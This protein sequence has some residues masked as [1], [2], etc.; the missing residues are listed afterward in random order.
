MKFFR[1]HIRLAATFM[2]LIF[3]QSLVLPTSLKALT[4]GA[5]QSEFSS[6]EPYDT[7]DMV[8]LATGDFTY[9]MPLIHVPSPE[10]GY[11]LSLSYHAGIRPEQVSG[12]VGLGW[13]INPG[14]ITRGVNSLPD[15]W[16]AS[17]MNLYTYDD[18]EVY[19]EW[20][21]SVN[22]SPKNSPVGGGF[23]VSHNNQ[24]GFG[25]SVDIGTS[26]ANASVGTDGWSAGLGLP[27]DF[28]KEA[29]EGGARMFAGY[30]GF[31]YGSSG[32]GITGRISPNG[33]Y[34][35]TKKGLA[36]KLISRS[37][38]LGMNLSAK[39]SGGYLSTPL[40]LLSVG[41][42]AGSNDVQ[43]RKFSFFVPIPIKP[44]LIW[45]TFRYRYFK[46]WL[47]KHD[48]K[49]AYGSLY[50][51]NGK[52]S[53]G[54]IPF[55]NDVYEDY[56]ISFP[57]FDDY[58][59]AAQGVS[60]KMKPRPLEMGNVL[61]ESK[62]LDY[63][64]GN[65]D[66]KKRTQVNY[67]QEDDFDFNKEASEIYF[68]FEN[69][70]SG[71]LRHQPGTLTGTLSET[72]G[73]SSSSINS[74]GVTK[75]TQNSKGESYYHAG[76][77][78]M[79]QGRHIEWFTNEMIDAAHQGQASGQRVWDAGFVEDPT[80]S[81]KRANADEVEAKGVGGFVV[82]AQDGKQYH[83]S[84]PVYNFE[85]IRV[86]EDKTDPE[87]K[88]F[89]SN[90]YDKFA[91]TW[92]LTA[93]TGPDYIDRNGDHQVDGG[94]WG[95]WVKFTYGNYTDF[96]GWANPYDYQNAS[97]NQNT[98]QYS[99]GRKEVYY[100]DAIETRSHT[101]YFL[102]S[103]KDD[104]QSVDFLRTLSHTSKIKKANRTMFNA[105]DFPF[106][107]C[108]D[109]NGNAY[110]PPVTVSSAGSYDY[111]IKEVERDMEM[112]VPHVNML[113]LDKI[114]LVKN[115][116][117]QLNGTEAS[118]TPVTGTANLLDNRRKLVE[119]SLDLGPGVPRIWSNYGYIC[120]SSSNWSVP[121]SPGPGFVRHDQ[122]IGTDDLLSW[123]STHGSSASHILEEIEFDQDYTL[124]P[125]TPNSRWNPSNPTIKD[126]KLT[127]NAVKFHG[128]GGAL[129]MPSYQFEYNQATLNPVYNETSSDAWGY[130]G[131]EN[132][133][134]NK[135]NVSAWSLAKIYFPEGGEM[136]IE[137]ESDS[138]HREAA[139]HRLPSLT[140][141]DANATNNNTRFE[142]TCD[143]QNI[144][145]TDWFIVGR[146]YPIEMFVLGEDSS[147]QAYS[148]GDEIPSTNQYF[149]EGDVIGS[150]TLHSK[151]VNGNGETVLVFDS[152][153]SIT[154][155]TWQA[156]DASIV[157]AGGKIESKDGI[158]YGGGLRVKNI[159]ISDGSGNDYTTKYDYSHPFENDGETSG[160]TSYSPYG[161]A[162]VPYVH[163]V[164]GP[165]VM[166]EYVTTWSEAVNGEQGSKTRY[167]FKVLPQLETAGSS[168]LTNFEMSLG[169]LF[170]VEDIQSSGS[171]GYLHAT[172]QRPN[173]CPNCSTELNLRSTILHNNLGG[174]GN[175]LEVETFDGF[176]DKI[177]HNQTEFYDPT[178]ADVGVFQES[179]HTSKQVLHYDTN[180]DYWDEFYSTNASRYYYP[181]QPKSSIAT[182]SVGKTS[183]LVDNY[184]L[185]TGQPRTT[186]SQNKLNEVFKSEVVHAAPRGTVGSWNPNAQYAEMGS[187]LFDISNKNMLTQGIYSKT[188]T[189]T[190]NLTLDQIT[191]FST[192]NWKTLDASAQTWNED[193]DYREY[194]SGSNSYLYV[195]SSDP[196]WRL[197]GTYIWKGFLNDDGTYDNS[198]QD[199]DP[200]NPESNGWIRVSKVTHYDPYSNIL[201]STYPFDLYPKFSS[202]KNGYGEL[203]LPIASAGSAKYTE[204]AF[205]G[206]EDV[207]PLTNYNKAEVSHSGATLYTTSS[208]GPA[209]PDFFD[210]NVHT[211]LHSM[212]LTTAG[213]KAFIFNASASGNDPEM[214]KERNYRASVW[215]K[216]ETS[217][218]LVNYVRLY[219]KENGT[220]ISST[221]DANPE[222]VAGDWMLL[223]LDF[224]PSASA[225]TIEVGLSCDINVSGVYADDFRVHPM[226]SSFSSV[227]YNP[228]TS[229]MVASLD[230]DNIA[231]KYVYDE[232]GRVIKVYVETKD[233]FRLSSEKAINYKKPLE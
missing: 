203:N 111:R 232:A 75:A 168:G 57:A 134:Y 19:K 155:C 115:G 105:N 89:E 176:G 205:S 51:K 195:N 154:N 186:Y 179:Y 92:L 128:K 131:P 221:T 99:F 73:Q 82:T 91:H 126:G 233:G 136:N 159:V 40:G 158:Q 58:N 81:A 118:Y 173:M 141:V 114:I 112:N 117:L 28:G 87:T 110:T 103:Q 3:L 212:H 129:I 34:L 133:N 144:D 181:N 125:E 206:A 160:V 12:W 218:S 61:G 76:D 157:Q 222:F 10:G 194:A 90:Q 219:Y 132:D 130:Y 163:D 122:V 198:F 35:F 229:E 101:A 184:D 177:S 192:L 174:L 190:T 170:W 231:T 149:S 137:Y 180:G 68:Y 71:Y 74:I 208:P 225:S 36:N 2:L 120:E 127:L 191:D 56:G 119:R 53:S 152:D 197:D 59:I 70:P 42:P 84:I 147:P 138:Y 22:I 66:D 171:Q 167:H 164:P 162:E 156:L 199:F 24:T 165:S 7:S 220:I 88:Y 200:A 38:S 41:Q 49:Q 140:I 16:D 95:Y 17:N 135:P 196:V 86:V 21:A 210:P 78:R 230:G 175:L 65:D 204:I 183:T 69:D 109:N 26:F 33:N 9:N 217:N 48:E 5:A 55:A 15:D 123:E 227:V 67:L 11:P 32:S 151:Y 96:Y 102:K 54:S 226:V 60:G 1:S 107:L 23:T 98:R 207:D 6:F 31:K 146:D 153:P 116:S 108:M 139:T 63:H 193:W 216:R 14:A 64:N 214:E 161:K 77:D 85:N 202:T 27:F 201:E 100:L 106:D 113:K 143:D 148:C 182:A 29:F 44:P 52:N 188:S 20:S 39:G 224:K 209:N 169:D 4:A 43:I 223:N 30:L 79:G 47:Y 97:G 93:I 178:S 150:F 13:N 215:V 46:W 187:K 50:A 213:Q 145:Y 121:G 124:C 62:I 18:G 142:I 185:V 83:F 166:Y 80:M 25:G 37:T 211:G 94:D 72:G 172:L 45:G 8:N 189:A 104:E 228:Y